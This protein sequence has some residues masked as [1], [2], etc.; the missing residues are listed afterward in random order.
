M[1]SLSLEEEDVSLSINGAFS[2]LGVDQLN[3]LQRQQRL[4]NLGDLLRCEDLIDQHKPSLPNR[5]D[6]RRVLGSSN[7]FDERCNQFGDIKVQKFTD[8][9]HEEEGISGDI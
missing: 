2:L 1:T 8:S 3:I 5:A 9:E 4:D 7:E 6:D